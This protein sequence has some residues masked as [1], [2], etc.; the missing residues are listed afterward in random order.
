MTV[1]KNELMDFEITHL[2][3]QTCGKHIGEYEDLKKPQNYQQKPISS[4]LVL[5]KP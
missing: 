3:Q 4:G 1:F 5:E 2:T